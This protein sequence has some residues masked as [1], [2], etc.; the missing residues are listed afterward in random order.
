MPQTALFNEDDASVDG[1]MHSALALTGQVAQERSLLPPIETIPTEILDTIFRIVHESS[2]YSLTMSLLNICSISLPLSQVC[3]HWRRTIR[4]RPSLWASIY[5]DTAH[6][7]GKARHIV[8]VHLENAGL[9][10]L[11]IKLLA[12][13]TALRSTF[14]IDLLSMIIPELQRCGDFTFYGDWSALAKTAQCDESFAFPHLHTLITDASLT[15]LFLETPAFHGFSRALKNAP[16]L[17]TVGSPTFVAPEVL[18]CHQLTTVRSHK[19]KITEMADLLRFCPNLKNLEVASLE[20]GSPPPN[21]VVHSS[22]RE[23]TIRANWLVRIVSSLAQFSLPALQI[24]TLDISYDENM[25][26]TGLTSAVN[27]AIQC[28][29]ASLQKLVLIAGPQS[30]HRT[31][32]RDILQI[33]PNLHHFAIAVYS[34]DDNE[35]EYILHLIQSLTITDTSQVFLAPKLTELRLLEYDSPITPEYAT[36]FL[37][38]VE[39][40]NAGI[41]VTRL[42]HAELKHTIE[43]AAQP[44]LDASIAERIKQLSRKGIR[45]AI[46]TI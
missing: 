29:S 12:E 7:H 11:R 22:L 32:C 9:H 30:M 23:L 31:L 10:P 3:A 15:A 45:C 25:D 37:D 4:S 18:P 2:K 38:M 24:F 5:I 42:T 14:A 21:V 19:L 8:K 20:D 13:P 34:E 27:A 36:A 44:F 17:A 16:K 43:W 1:P 28:F 40:R 41:G 35:S 6:V 33:C 39:S 46:S 26:L